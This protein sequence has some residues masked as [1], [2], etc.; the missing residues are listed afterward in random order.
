MD[1]LDTYRQVGIESAITWLETADIQAI[2][3]LEVIE[4]AKDLAPIGSVESSKF[5]AAFIEEVCRQVLTRVKT[6]GSDTIQKFHVFAEVDAIRW[7]TSYGQEYIKDLS[8]QEI[9]NIAE[10]LFA[11]WHR[12]ES[13]PDY[14]KKLYLEAFRKQVEVLVKYL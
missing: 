6:Y 13:C 7:V 12:S 1:Y 2:T 8:D 3:L 9:K 4:A 11:L 14:I 10:K 5:M